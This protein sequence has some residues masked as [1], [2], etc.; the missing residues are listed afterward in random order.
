MEYILLDLEWNGAYCKSAGKF[1]N[2]IIEIGAVRLNEQLEEVDGFRQMVRSQ[3]T[4]KLCGRF[5]E[6]TNI[7][8]EEMAAGVPFVQALDAYKVWAGK[9]AVTMTWSNTD[10][11]VM[12]ENCRLFGGEER[13]PCIGRYVDLQRYVQEKLRER[14]VEH[15]GQMSLVHAAEAFGLDTAGF[16]LHRAQDDSR[17]CCELLR[18]TY[19]EAALSACFENTLAENY[20]DRLTFKSY[21]IS[22]LN[23][24]YI[25]KNELRFRCESCGRFARRMGKWVFKNRMFRANFRCGNCGHTFRGRIG[26]KKRY[27]SVDI[28]RVAEPIPEEAPA[29]QTAA[30]PEA[31][32]QTATES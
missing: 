1:V 14:G 15:K 17:V 32:V 31:A 28:K 20:Y 24:P 19:D 21:M 12:L 29:G 27:D 2:E 8:N 10:L 30:Q 5:K 26:F 23:S 25:D 6:L 16:D 11:Y 7:T 9:N 3:L 22:D 4:K 18:R 13:I